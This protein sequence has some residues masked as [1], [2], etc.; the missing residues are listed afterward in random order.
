MEFLDGTWKKEACEW[1]ELLG[2]SILNQ[3]AV[4]EGAVHSIRNMGD[5]A[6]VILRRREGLFQTVYENDRVNVSIH[7][8][9]E[10]MTVRIRGLYVRRSARLTE[11]N[12]VSGK[13][14]FFL[15]RQNRCQWRLI[16][17]SCILLWKQS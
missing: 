13:S 15:G 5:V 8:L 7:E 10:A 1:K 9:K 3:E 2:D 16:N 6:F 14:G 17:G 12:C 4:V 11:E